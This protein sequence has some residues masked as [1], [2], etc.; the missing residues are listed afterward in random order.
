MSTYQ[1][2]II[3]KGRVFANNIFYAPLA[4]FTDYPFR[5]ISRRFN[6]GLLFCEMAKMEAL[7]RHDTDSFKLL[8]YDK[9]MHPIGAQLCGSNF[10]LVKECAKI[11]EDL[12]FD[13]L[14]FNC[15]CPVD[16]VTKDG[17]GSAMLK[18]PQLLEEIL[19]E[20][21]AT[22]KIPVSVKI[23]IGWDDKQINALQILKIA[24]RSNVDAIFIHGRTRAQGYSGK[25]NWEII[26][27]CKNEAR[28]IK[29][30][31]NGDLFDPF[32]VKAM[33]EQTGCDGVLLAR[34]MISQPWMADEIAN[35][36][37][38]AF[39]PRSIQVIKDLLLEH[40]QVIYEYETDKKSFLDMKRTVF[41]YLQNCENSKKLKFLVSSAQSAVEVMQ[42]IRDYDWQLIKNK[43]QILT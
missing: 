11:I 25:A 27:Q 41:S 37:P 5:R 10:K 32:A 28:K 12:G 34:G 33:F 29:V 38:S 6:P 20:L 13:W 43:K 26:R 30:F 2:N 19:V 31:G 3:I 35:L 22:V 4:G 7:I 16:K 18:N 15:G 17:S 9:D 8:D 40:L 21:V 24:E 23:R 42:I 36:D 39:V 1:K 14:D